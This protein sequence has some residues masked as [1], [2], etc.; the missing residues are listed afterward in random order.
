LED[1]IE[2]IIGS[3]EDEFEKEP[4]LFLADTLSP[5]RIILDV[6]GPD[7]LAAIHQICA[8]IKPS[9]LPLPRERIERAVAEREKSMSTYLGHGVAVPHARIDGLE[10][11][12]L[13]FAQSSSGIPVASSTEKVHILFMLL[14]PAN[15]PQYQ[16]R[17]LARI[18]GVMQSEYVVERL[19]ETHDAGAILEILRAADP[20]TLG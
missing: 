14:T 3:V 6:T 15:I 9:E 20:G 19:R 4:P 5:E 11:P 13:I 8:R 12:I 2:E 17:L 10:R 1:V 18:C 7:I 16:V